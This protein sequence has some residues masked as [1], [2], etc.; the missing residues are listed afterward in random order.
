MMEK[1]EKKI[2]IESR[3]SVNKRKE[4]FMI[5]TIDTINMDDEVK[6]AHMLFRDAIL[7]EWLRRASMTAM[8]SAATTTTTNVASTASQMMAGRS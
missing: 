1:M 3:V 6:T 4:D 7:E 2:E 8:T 5:M